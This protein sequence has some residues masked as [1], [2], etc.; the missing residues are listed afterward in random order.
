MRNELRL[1]AT[2]L[3]AGLLALAVS[4]FG[5]GADPADQYYDC[6]RRNDMRMLNALVEQQRREMQ[7]QTRYHAAALRGR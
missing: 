7:G 3:L 6:I 1:A 4:G 5:Q 2:A